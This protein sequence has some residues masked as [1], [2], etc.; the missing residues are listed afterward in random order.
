MQKL[1][2]LKLHQELG[3]GRRKEKGRG[4][5]FMYDIFDTL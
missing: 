2:L 3:E 1:Y 5:K 4:D